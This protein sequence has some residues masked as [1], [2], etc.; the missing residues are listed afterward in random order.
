MS[1]ERSPIPDI[2]HRFFA[3]F[4]LLLILC[5]GSCS[6][7]RET[8]VRGDSSNPIPVRLFTVVE[9]AVPRQV[10]AVG[11]LFPLEESTI[12][13][14]VEGRVERV[15][16]D[17]GDRVS[18][19]QVLVT[20]S[21]VELRYELDRQRAAVLGV[22]ARLGLGA[23]DPLPRDPSQVASV[24][25]AAAEM[26]DAGQKN[27]R[28]E[29]LFRDQLISQ[30]QLDEAATR[31]KGARATHDL[32]LQEV[33]QLKAQLQ[34]SETAAKLA[35]KKLADTSI[36]APFPGSI[37]QRRVS[38]GE[39]LRVQSPVAVVVR[40]DQ[41][42][43][44]L[45]VPEK[46]AG[47]VKTG[48]F[49][50][51]KVEAYPNEAFR[52]TVLRI[53]PAV[54][55]ETRTFEVE[56]LIPNGDGRLKPGFFIQ[57]SLPSDLTEKMLLAPDKAVSY[58]YGIYKVFVLKGSTVEER[59]VQVGAHH[60]S[61]LEILSGLALGDRVAVAVKGELFSGATVKEASAKDAK[62]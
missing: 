46:W 19:G 12:S 43:A 11:S 41:L 40:T 22:R 30:Q 17:V 38:P 45:A 21:P 18:E 4:S 49:V 55:Q 27:L 59:D 31:F 6:R 44:R 3:V 50:E 16:A 36:R 29:Q 48:T 20:L 23:Q 32:A 34:S 10:Q 13:S 28:A 58:R 52:G 8:S 14:E 61:Q 47:V 60:D 7:A 1:V 39:F 57:G 54:T 5:V 62:E 15:L 51:V 9:Q 53:N 33:E 56:A 35:E 37:K 2:R 24:V 25:R 42:R 26:F